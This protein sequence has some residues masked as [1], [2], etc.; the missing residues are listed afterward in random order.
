[1]MRPGPSVA[2]VCLAVLAGQAPAHACS[3]SWKPGYSPRE[4]K[5]RTDVR[6]VRGIFHVVDV[7]GTVTPDGELDT[8][9]IYGRL[10]TKRGTGWDTVQNYS[11][12]SVECGAYRKPTAEAKG[13]FWIERRQTDGRYAM[14][15]WEG[16][17]LPDPPARD[18]P[19]GN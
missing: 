5:L 11:H 14:L 7:Q 9:T 10:D 6:L 12:F 13:I 19:K 16:E 3:F 1:M 4:I 15:L 18:T 17:Y 8:G 2:A